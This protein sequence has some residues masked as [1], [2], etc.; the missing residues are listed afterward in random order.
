MNTVVQ[1]NL[2]T[3]T[4]LGKKKTVF[5]HRWALFG[6][7]STDAIYIR[8]HR[9]HTIFSLFYLLKNK[10]QIEG[11]VPWFLCLPNDQGLEFLTHHTGS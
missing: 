10:A 9:L 4:A 6:G 1:S 7:L 3:K 2:Q 11:K 8:V 5:V